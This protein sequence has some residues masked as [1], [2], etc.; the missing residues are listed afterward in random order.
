MY[1]KVV[2][3]MTNCHKNSARMQ[4]KMSFSDKMTKKSGGGTPYLSIC[5]HFS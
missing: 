1:V 4:N 5:K 3:I 2:Y